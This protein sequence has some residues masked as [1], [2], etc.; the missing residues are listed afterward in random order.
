M[1]FP[2]ISAQLLD[3]KLKNVRE[4]R[5]ARLVVDCPG[6]VMQLR[7]A[8]KRRALTSKCSTS[9]NF[10]PKTSNVSAARPGGRGAG[11]SRS[12]NPGRAEKN[13]K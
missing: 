11:G 5:A 2:E 8:A 4:T 13:L 7:G 9:R 12:G 10:W 3:K 6:C 1:K